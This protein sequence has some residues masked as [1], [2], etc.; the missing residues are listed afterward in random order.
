MRKAHG[1]VV[2]GGLLVLV[3]A[4]Q[5][6]CWTLYDDYYLP[7]TNPALARDAGT[8]SG[9]PPSC[10]PSENTTPVADAC[11]VFVSP[12][13][14]DTAGKGTQAAP[15]KTITWALT[16]GSTLYA[17]AGATAYSEPVV[18]DKAVTLFG[19][20][21]CGTWAYTAANKTQL[22]A[23][24]DAVPLTLSSSASGSDVEDFAITAADA[25]KDGGSSIGIIA[26]TV[27]A[28][29]SRT[30]VTAGD[31]KDGL[32]GTT[33]TT[34]V[35]PTDPTDTTIVG[36]KG[37]NACMATSSQLGGDPVTNPLC[38]S[39]GGG[40]GN[41]S[42][43]SGSNGDANPA[44][45]QTAL[46]GQGQPATDMGTWGCTVGAGA[47]GTNGSVGM[48]GSGAK[49]TD[50]GMLNGTTG[51]A[52]VTGLPGSAGS[53]GQGGGGGGGAK[54]KSACAGA[55]GG[56]GGAG[57]CGGNGG[58]GGAAG[59]ASIGIVSLGATLT[60]GMV[61]ISLG[62]GGKGGD[63]AVGEGGGV[64]G[65]GGSGGTGD[66][67]APATEPACDGGNG[68]NGGQGGTGG[69][70]RGGHAIRIA[71][72]GTTAPS[73][74]GVTFPGEGAGGVGGMGDDSMGNMGDGAPGVVADVQ[75]F[76]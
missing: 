72:T 76:N 59:G 30:D 7:L 47:I 66:S 21:D 70:G 41:G 54:G 33:P 55:S 3:P 16:M 2:W 29:F 1:F 75:A 73:T 67:T 63:G 37:G 4:L 18:I 62:T 38:S 5:A 11:G 25:M 53:P 43:S 15:Y 40:G 9:P 27:T 36:I 22:T 68:G 42:T 51:Y 23:A 10:I 64:G 13:G 74:T 14:S 52:G 57:G 49:S 6:G 26:N 65:K 24:S 34:S 19:A 46:G 69:G 61:T 12:S 17:C 20:L 50:L 8:D 39:T 31:G 28:S 56:S 44:N 35:G 58:G 48:S 71:Y 32:K 45:A 60:F